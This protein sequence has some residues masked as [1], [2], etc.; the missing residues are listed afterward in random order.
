MKPIYIVLLVNLLVWTG[1][2]S[3]LLYLENKL[4]RIE[5]Q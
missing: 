2:F 3:Y 1:I 5:K 4:K